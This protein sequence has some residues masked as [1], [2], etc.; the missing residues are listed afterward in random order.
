MKRLW[1]ITGLALLAGCGQTGALY[2]PEGD[3]DSPIQI[4]PVSDAA[5]AGAGSVPASAAAVQPAPP[6]TV[7]AGGQ[8]AAS[9]NENPEESPAP[10]PRR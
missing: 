2:L 1:M 3:T 10:K 7:P 9:G 4:R 6:P 5:P 8:P